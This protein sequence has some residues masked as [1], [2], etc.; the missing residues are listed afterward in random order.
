M[1]VRRAVTGAAAAAAALVVTPCAFAHAHVSPGV[2][3]A[4][5]AQVFTLA[6]PTEKEGAATTKIELTPP[7]GFAIDSFVASPGWK[8]TV[9]QRGSG[10]SA[11]ITHV[12]WTGGHVRTGEDAAF[13]FLAQADQARTYT[14]A[15]RQTYSDGSVVDWEGPESSDTPSPTV[16]AKSTLGGGGSSLLPIAAIVVA[17]VALVCAAVA[18]VARSGTR[19]LA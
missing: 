12:T 5:T 2:V 3:Q 16:Q 4:K 19:P 10:D 15:V 14:F 6:V 8:R 1:Q 7:P 18:L 13:E 9:Q 11:T 17:A